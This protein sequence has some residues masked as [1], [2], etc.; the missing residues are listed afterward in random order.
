MSTPADRLIG[1][2]TAERFEIEALGIIGYAPLLAGSIHSLALSVVAL[3][4]DRQA[5]IELAAACSEVG[6]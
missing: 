1:D 3:A 4:R 5:R 2:V 6:L